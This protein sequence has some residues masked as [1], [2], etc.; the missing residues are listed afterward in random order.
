MGGGGGGRDTKPSAGNRRCPPP[1]PITTPHIAVSCNPRRSTADLYPHKSPRHG[2]AHTARFSDMIQ[3]RGRTVR[4]SQRGSPTQR[5]QIKLG[6]ELLQTAAKKA[7]LLLLFH[8]RGGRESPVKQKLFLD[9]RGRGFAGGGATS[10][11]ITSGGSSSHPAPPSGV[12]GRGE[13]RDAR[14]CCSW[15][16]TARPHSTSVFPPNHHLHQQKKK[17]MSQ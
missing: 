4:G 17:S 2:R 6:S 8:E 10:G 9:D 15:I 1:L 11:T 3:S 5:L 7:Q 12:S 13:G 16:N 14:G